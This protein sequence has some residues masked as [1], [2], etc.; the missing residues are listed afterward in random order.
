MAEINLSETSYTQPNCCVGCK[1]Y[2]NKD[3][4]SVHCPT[5]VALGSLG[6]IKRVVNGDTELDSIQDAENL[7][8]QLPRLS[9][10]AVLCGS[11]L[12]AG[13]IQ[14]PYWV[15]TDLTLTNYTVHSPVQVIPSS[16][17]SV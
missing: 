4:E 16:V 2:A 17:V 9:D 15:T 13:I 1:H 10:A 7:V 12:A 6:R 11:M 14:K 5:N 8:D 3:P